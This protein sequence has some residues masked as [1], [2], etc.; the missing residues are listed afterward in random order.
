MNK[1]KG[2]RTCL[3]GWDK[4]GDYLVIYPKSKISLTC[5]Y[6]IKLLETIWEQ[7]SHLFFSFPSTHPLTIFFFFQLILYLKLCST[8]FLLAI[9]VCFLNSCTCSS[10]FVE[11]I[12]L[13]NMWYLRYHFLCMNSCLFMCNWYELREKWK[14]EPEFVKEKQTSETEHPEHVSIL[15]FQGLIQLCLHFYDIFPR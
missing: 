1:L 2:Y 5:W 6:F 7:L 9:K 12:R 11:G 10:C 15:I 4:W 8:Y 3:D 14:H 13:M